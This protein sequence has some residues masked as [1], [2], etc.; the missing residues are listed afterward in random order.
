MFGSRESVRAIKLWQE[1]WAPQIISTMATHTDLNN[2]KDCGLMFSVFLPPSLL[3]PHSQWNENI[4]FFHW[5]SYQ[6]YLSVKMGCWDC[7]DRKNTMKVIPKKTYLYNLCTLFQIFWSKTQVF[8]KEKIRNL[9]N[10]SL[11]LIFAII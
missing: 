6:T 8:Y 7:R 4:F 1:Q 3:Y 2:N 9:S 5:A 10:Y 11:K